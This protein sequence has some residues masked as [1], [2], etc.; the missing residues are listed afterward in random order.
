VTFADAFAASPL[1]YPIALDPR[2]DGVRLVRL[3]A[4]DYAAASFLDGRLLTPEMPSAAVPWCDVRSAAGTLP[5]RC[6]F[7]FHISHVGSTLLSRLVGQHPAFLSLRE[8]AVLRLLAEAQL[9][10]GR[11]DCPWPPAEWEDRLRVCLAAWSRTFEPGQTAVVKAT[12]YVAEMAADL[13]GRVPT[14]RAV[15]MFVGPKVFLQALLGGAMSDVEA[16]AEKRLDR[17]HRRLGEARWQL[18]D[19]SAGERVAMSWLSEMAAL[20]AAAE[21]Y[22]PRVVWLDFDRFLADPVAGFAAVLAHFGAGDAPAAARTIIGGPTMDQYAK[23]PAHRFDAVMRRQLLD[24]AAHQHAAEIAKGL[25]WLD[26]AATDPAVA[27]VL[28]HSSG[29]GAP[30]PSEPEA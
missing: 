27:E 25:T 14:A 13:M 4:A 26:R 30:R 16:S 2:T 23:A 15:F 7:I 3:D 19:L 12:S 5:V 20:H 21:A 6:H 11:P 1:L 29:T 18:G 22:P 17:L 24:Q 28:E 9:T 8:P 10:L